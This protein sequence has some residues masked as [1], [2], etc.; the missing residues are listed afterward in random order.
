MSYL[1][2]PAFAI[3]LIVGLCQQQGCQASKKAETAA[4]D[5]T[6]NAVTPPLEAVATAHPDRAVEV[7]DLV[8]NWTTRSEKDDAARAIPLLQVYAA[9]HPDEGVGIKLLIRGWQR[10]LAAFDTAAT[11]PSPPPPPK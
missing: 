1:V 2:L 7:R 11:S 10:R 3:M 4:K 6:Y 8:D 9:E 5:D